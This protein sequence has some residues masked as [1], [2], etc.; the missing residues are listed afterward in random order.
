M[1][2]C[3]FTGLLAVL[4]I[5]ALLACIFFLNIVVQGVMQ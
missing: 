4:V 1:K 3:I 2:R 5:A